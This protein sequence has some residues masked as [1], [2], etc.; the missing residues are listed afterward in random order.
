MRKH[1][2]GFSLIEIVVAIAILGLI[3]VPCGSALLM[4]IRINE[5]AQQMMQAQLAVSSAVET[6]MAEGIEGSSTTID[7]QENEPDAST[8]AY[9][10]V[11]NDVDRFPDV[12]VHTSKDA[13]GPYYTVLVK[14]NEGL[15]RIV[16]TIRAKEVAEP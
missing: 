11:E 12:V 15:V 4:S 1:N 2:E 3:V 5:K 7:L 14:D 6:L 8:Q 13:A 9:D 16:T 10:I